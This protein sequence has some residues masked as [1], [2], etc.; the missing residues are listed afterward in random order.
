[1]NEI[2]LHLPKWNEL[3]RKQLLYICQLFRNGFDQ[4]TFRL[5]A[6]LNLTGIKALPQKIEKDQVYWA[7]KKRKEV[8]WLTDMELTWFLQFVNYLTENCRLTVNLFPSFRIGIRRY[9]GPCKEC[10]NIS[11]KE[12]IHAEGQFF[13]YNNAKSQRKVFYLNMLCAVL[14]RPQQPHYHPMRPD[15]NGDRR[16]PFN[17]F[18]YPRRANRFRLLSMNKRYAI[19]TFYAGCRNAMVEAH[20]QVFKPS[21]VSSEA[22]ASPVKGFIQLVSDLNQGDVTKNEQI[23]NSPGWDVLDLLE[24]MIEKQ[25]P[26]KK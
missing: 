10:R 2:N 11:W 1:M 18:V 7:F 22:P 23:F 5:K 4:N 6:F 26:V 9:W 12:F 14:Y 13:A 19:Y 3:T 21:G 24:R 20:P 17:D 8:F 16:Q 15:Y 25:K